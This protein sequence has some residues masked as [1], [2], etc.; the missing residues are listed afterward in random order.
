MQKFITLLLC[1]GFLFS[2]SAEAQRKRTQPKPQPVKP[3]ITLLTLGHTGHGKTTLTAAMAKVLSKAG[4]K[5]LVTYDEIANASE[6]NFTGISVNAAQIEY[7]SPKA[8]Y[9][10]LDCRNNDDCVKLLSSPNSK[11]KNAILVISAT[12]G[13]MPGTREHLELAQKN[14]IKSIVVYLNKVD[15]IGDPELF[16]LL[17]SEIRHLLTTYGFKGDQ[18]PIIRGSALLALN[19]ERDDIGKNSITKLLNAMDASFVK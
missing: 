19:G 13:P 8:R 11:I 14:G 18:V 1:I 3:A 12:D 5:K 10:H 7:E 6:T 16:K 4:Q 17:E 9:T 15:M 2:F